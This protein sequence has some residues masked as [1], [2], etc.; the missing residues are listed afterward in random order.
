MPKVEFELLKWSAFVKTSADKGRC[1]IAGEKE[2]ALWG[3]ILNGPNKWD[4]IIRSLCHGIHV[5]FV[6]NL[7]NNDGSKEK[8]TLQTP[9]MG[10]HAT[11][12]GDNCNE[13]IIQ[14]CAE[15]PEPRELLSKKFG[16]A[17]ETRLI[18]YFYAQYSTAD[19]KGRIK[20]FLS[21]EEFMEKINLEF[22]LK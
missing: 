18:I 1:R 9:I 10:I 12:Y 11:Q 7:T 5:S 20:F 2:A 6:I 16:E 19:R 17:Y 8:F 22:V 15:Y 21:S 3:K 13:W 4:L 14:G